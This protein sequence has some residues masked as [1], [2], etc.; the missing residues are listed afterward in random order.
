MLNLPFSELKTRKNKKG[1]IE[2]F[3]CIRKKYVT[4]TPEETV[5]QQFI[6][7]MIT[8]KGFPASLI[9]I[10]KG[11]LV[12]N[13]QKR[14]DA[15]AHNNMGE[16]IILMEFKAPEIKLSQEVF[17]QISSYNI[18]LKVK[19]LII[20]NGITHY[21]CSIDYKKGEILFMEDI[22]NYKDVI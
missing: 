14:F 7:F 17:E 10:E 3:D 9:A 19:Y 1:T 2:V 16:P 12:N 21:C 15:V 4:L 13:L 20:S 8:E 18:K 6:N 11:L 22:P 5:R